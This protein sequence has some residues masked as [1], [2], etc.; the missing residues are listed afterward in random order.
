MLLAVVLL[1]LAVILLLLAVILLLLA[2]VLLLLAVILLLLAVILLLLA[3]ILLLLA[4]ILLLLAVIL[5]LL[6]AL[7]GDL[8]N[9]VVVD[10]WPEAG[11]AHGLQADRAP[12]P[13]AP[14]LAGVGGGAPWPQGPGWGRVAIRVASGG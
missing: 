10:P 14:G 2:V 12:L 9:L 8:V 6:A 7:P 5:L 3:V 13:W 11:H 1:L 4:V